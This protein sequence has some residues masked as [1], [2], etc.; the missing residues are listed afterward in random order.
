MFPPPASRDYKSLI[1]WF[2]AKK[3]VLLAEMRWIQRKEDIVTLRPGREAA[4]FEELVEGL[5]GVL[6]RFFTAKCGCNVIKVCWTTAEETLVV[7]HPADAVC[8]T[9]TQGENERQVRP[10][11]LAHAHRWTGQ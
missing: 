5:V 9:G 8:D 3:P 2:E 6:D 4:G 11:L 10:A 7:D 1:W